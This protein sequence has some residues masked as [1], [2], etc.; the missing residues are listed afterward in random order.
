MVLSG[1]SDFSVGT[2]LAQSQDVTGRK[3]TRRKL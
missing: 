2:D 3:G 1:V